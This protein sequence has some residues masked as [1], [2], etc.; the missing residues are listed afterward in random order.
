MTDTDTKLK[1]CP[2]CGGEA[3]LVENDYHDYSIG[4]EINSGCVAEGNIDYWTSKEEVIRLWNTRVI[5]PSTAK[6][7]KDLENLLAPYLRDDPDRL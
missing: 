1:P 2:F 7:I 3:K 5:D 6:R 4:C